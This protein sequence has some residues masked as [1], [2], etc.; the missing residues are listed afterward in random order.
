MDNGDISATVLSSLALLVSLVTLYLTFFHKR[1]KLVA[2]LAAIDFPEPSHSPHCT[3]DFALSNTGTLEL[4]L[5]E[6]SIDA[7]SPDVGLLPEI[8]LE[9]LPLVVS[10]GQVKLV[11]VQVP[12][13]FIRNIAQRGGGV[14]FAFHIFSSRGDLYLARKA[15]S[16]LDAS[17]ELPK[18]TWS[19]F[20]LGRV[21]T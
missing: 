11:K 12:N 2:C 8:H 6:I 20:S 15:V 16:S 1:A 21:E 18:R 13:L 9:E 3:F 19:P 10:P 5:R 7:S 14:E 4:L 17:L